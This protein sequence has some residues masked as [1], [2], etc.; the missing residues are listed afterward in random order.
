MKISPTNT[1]ITTALTKHENKTVKTLLMAFSSGV[2]MAALKDKLVESGY[3]AD[4]QNGMKPVRIPRAQQEE[5]VRTYAEYSDEFIKKREETLS[6]K[7]INK[8]LEFININPKLGK[9]MF[10]EHFNKLLNTFLLLK[11]NRGFNELNNIFNKNKPTMKVIDNLVSG[12]FSPETIKTVKNWKKSW[13]G[14]LAQDK[15]RNM[16]IPEHREVEVGNFIK[17]LSSCL[18]KQSL[19]EKMTLYRLEGKDVLENIRVGN[20]KK[21][22][23]ARILTKAEN[24]QNFNVAEKK[25]REFVL[26]HEITGVQKGFMSTTL[27][28]SFAEGFDN[29][30]AS[31]KNNQNI[32]WTF[33]TTKGVKG[34]FI[35]GLIPQNSLEFE[36]EILVQ[37][38]S[39]FKIEDIKYNKRLKMWEISAKL[40]GS[41]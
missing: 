2:G 24:S 38:G 25:I 3:R 22:D 34:M 35:E 6:K 26:D 7:D 40:S 9:K 14:A 8:F 30:I 32:L 23:L 11:D 5:I 27:D 31:Q 13:T 37:K 10:N 28:K 16:S 21:L 33:T 4:A 1:T 41:K 18:D 15:L 17:K 12:N 20:N 19:P 29:K 39:T 36:Q